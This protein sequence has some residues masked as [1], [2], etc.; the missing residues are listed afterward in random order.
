MFAR[1]TT[2]E[3]QEGRASESVEQFQPAIDRVRDLDGFVDAFFLF[4]RDGRHAISM[5]LWE[6]LETMER[7]RVAASSARTEAAGDAGA[8]VT[9]TYELE[10]G[11]RAAADD[12]AAEVLLGG[13][14]LA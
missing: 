2:Y 12:A 4:E 11:I 3:L 10:V 8:E 13:L 6:S 5:T 7:S 1:V 9:S 14:G